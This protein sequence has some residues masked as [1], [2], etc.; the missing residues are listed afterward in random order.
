MGRCRREVALVP[1]LAE[2]WPGRLPT[3]ACCVRVSERGWRA[4]GGCWTVSRYG[5]LLA[6]LELR[7][8]GGEAAG[9]VAHGP[10]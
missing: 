9:E 6:L 7:F 2:S 4:P 5:P 3:A 1:R 10:H 8:E